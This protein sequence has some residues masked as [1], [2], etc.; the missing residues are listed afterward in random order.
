MTRQQKCTRGIKKGPLV[1]GHAV[2]LVGWGSRDGT[3]YWIVKNSWGPGWGLGG[4]FFMLRGKN[5]CE[6]EEN[7]V[8]YIPDFFFPTGQRQSWEDAQH[9]DAFRMPAQLQAGRLRANTEIDVVAGGI[10]AST[11]YTRRVMAT[12]PWIDVST[13]SRTS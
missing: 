3:D 11:G 2:E 12:M 13:A 6:I 4:Y 7:V 5:M 10:D 1:G 9:K 8:A